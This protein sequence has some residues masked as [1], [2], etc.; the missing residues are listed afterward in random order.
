MVTTG[1]PASRELVGLIARGID[2]YRRGDW[3]AALAAFDEAVRSDPTSPE[4]HN[5]RGMARRAAGDLAGAIG[6]FGRALALAPD[7]PDAWGNRALALRDAGRPREALADFDRMLP[8][9][10]GVEAAAVLHARASVHVVRRDFASAVADC[11]EAIR[12]HPAM[13]AA[14]VSRAHARYHLRDRRASDDYVRAFE[15]EPEVAVAEIMRALVEHLR[16][17]APLVLRNCDKH[18]RDTPDD[19]IAVM[20]RGLTLLLLGRDACAAPDLTR[21]AAL[22]PGHEALISRLI[23]EARSRRQSTPAGAAAVDALFG[24]GQ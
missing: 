17:D 4:A 16:L 9:T 14:Y 24:A 2:D 11:D 21:A 6:D 7:Y 23:A 18:L 20:R 3:A 13:P 19:L 8:L 12:L 22:A 15:M 5:N 1:R 10:E